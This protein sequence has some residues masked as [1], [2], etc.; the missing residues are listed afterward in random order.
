MALNDRYM[1]PLGQGEVCT[2]G[3][4]LSA[5]LPPGIGIASASVSAVTNTNPVAAAPN[6]SF[7]A[8]GFRGRRCW[9]TVAGQAEGVDLQ[10]RWVATDSQGNTWPRTILALCAETS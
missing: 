10:I 6:V 4:D 5:I 1:P 7:G 9:A 3:L 8:V 2:L